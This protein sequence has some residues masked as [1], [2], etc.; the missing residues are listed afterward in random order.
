M[1]MCQLHSEKVKIYP[2]C[3]FAVI[4][5]G[6]GHAV[7]EKT[8]NAGDVFLGHIRGVHFEFF[9]DNLY[10]HLYCK[11]ERRACAARNS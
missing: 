6:F 5:V 1:P 2:E 3:N 4:V 11:E 9:H 10:E 8:P 7:G